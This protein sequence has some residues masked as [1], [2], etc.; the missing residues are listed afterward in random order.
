ME[1]ERSD[2]PKAKKE[3]PRDAKYLLEPALIEYFKN[4]NRL[5]EEDNWADP[6]EKEIFIKNTFK[7]I[8]G[9]EARLMSHNFCS[10]ILEKLMQQA[11][12]FHLRVFFSKISGSVW[13]LSRKR[14]ASH[15]IQALIQASSKFVVPSPAEQS[16]GRLKSLED[17]ILDFS[18]ELEPNL[19]E[20][21]KDTFA[22]HVLRDLFILLSGKGSLS[23]E[24]LT[25]SSS[26]KEYKKKIKSKDSFNGAD[27]EVPPS[28]KKALAKTVKFLCEDAADFKLLVT[29]TCASPT[30]QLLLL[31]A[32]EK[33]KD[34]ILASILK[35][36]EQERK[37]FVLSLCKQPIGSHFLQVVFQ[38]ISAAS[39]K[40]CF[41]SCFRGNVYALSKD[42][43]AN[44]VVQD[45]I[46]HC[47]DKETFEALLDE[48]LAHASE[49]V[50]LNR[51]HVI[52]KCVQ[53]AAQ[54]QKCFKKCM[55]LLS[56][57]FAL[58]WEDGKRVSELI[59]GKMD[60]STSLVLQNVFHFPPKY[61]DALTKPLL[62]LKA[63]N[64]IA[65]ANSA[66]SSRILESFYDGQAVLADKI[67]F[68]TSSFS[69]SYAK[70][71]IGKFSSHLV[72]RIW[73]I[74]PISLKVAIAQEMVQSKKI[75]EDSHCGA[76]LMR[77]FRIEEFSYRR[78]EW[79]KK[80]HS[81][82]KKRH[83]LQDLLDE[84]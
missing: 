80:I 69:G 6:E 37:A 56:A 52:V 12:S 47:K 14:F 24:D 8:D 17:S 16:D 2:R 51:V 70:L 82:D 4:A 32:E 9:I 38:C 54:M 62:G 26:S 45:V 77:N 79:T 33:A 48:L 28:F 15:V 43:S 23:N 40:K 10:E 74:A 25:R 60:L 46:Q 61:S 31:V 7:E 30:M 36:T 68:A 34:L 21:L 44:H 19:Q 73:K 64:A 53:K 76:I 41:D 20:A 42:I 50:Q 75:I 57:A 35:G 39:F 13:Q 59:T 5:L 81:N 84:E 66:V 63:E 58:D 78:E 27:F 29:S 67:A 18:K 55:K 71:C 72:E 83:L 1:K 49:L 65:L 22:C 11:S 3:E